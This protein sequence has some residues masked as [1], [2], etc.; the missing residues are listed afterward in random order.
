MS[1]AE[2]FGGWI[3][4]VR[5]DTTVVVD[6]H[7]PVPLW[8]HVLVGKRLS[9]FRLPD[10]NS[11]GNSNSSTHRCYATSRI[12]AEADR[13]TGWSRVIVKRSGAAKYVPPAVAGYVIAALDREG[14]LRRHHLLLRGLRRRRQTVPSRSL[15]LTTDEDRVRI[16]E[17][18]DRRCR[19]SRGCR[20]RGSRLLQWREGLLV[21]PR[22]M[23]G[24][25]RSSGT[26]WRNCSRQA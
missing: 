16:A 22:T 24:C 21:W 14:L 20:P 18:I 17:V 12:D 15:G 7:R 26:R 6:E 13:L 8:Q 9:I 5:G 3:Q 2:E 19:G 10:T 25:C 23:P 11:L 4:A 1:N